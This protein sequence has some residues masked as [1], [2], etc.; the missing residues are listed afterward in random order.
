MKKV[1]NVVKNSKYAGKIMKMENFIII[2]QKSAKK[3]QKKLPTRRLEHATD[4]L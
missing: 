2:Y 4:G 1:L 3:N